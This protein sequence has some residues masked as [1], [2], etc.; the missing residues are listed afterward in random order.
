MTLFE[1]MGLCKED[2]ILIQNL[3]E[4]QGYR[5]KRLMKEFPTKG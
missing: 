2:Y 1:K 5:A 4:F 3:Y